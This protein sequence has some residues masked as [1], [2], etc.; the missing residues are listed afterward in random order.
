MRVVMVTQWFDPEPTFKGLLF[1]KELQRR[2]HEVEVVTGFPNY[3]GGRVYDGYRIRAYQREVIDGI[4]VHRVPL[5][6][7]HDSSAVKRVLNY[8]SFASAAA[9]KVLSGPRPEVIYAYHP[10]GTVALPAAV[11]RLVRGVPFVYDVQDLWPDT[12]S[13]TGMLSEGRV[14]R[15]VGRAMGATYGL[16]AHIVVLSEGFRARLLEGGVPS[17]KVTVIPNWAPEHEVV[18]DD[19]TSSRERLGLDRTTNVVFAGAIGPAQQLDVVLDAAEMMLSEPDVCF[20]L[21]GSGMDE[22]RLRALAS[23]RGLDNVRFLPRRP[24]SEVG[25]VLAAGDALLVHLRPDPLF[26]ITVP[27]K[28]QTYL[29]AGKPVLMGVRGDAARLVT[30]SGAGICFEPGNPA[31]LARAVRE[32]ARLSPEARRE[33]GRAGRRYYDERLSLRVGSDAFA[34]VLETAARQRHAWQR[35]K[36]GMDVAASAIGLTLF[37][38]PGAAVAVLVRTRLGSPVFFRQ[39]RPGRHGRPFTMVKFRTMTDEKDEQGHLLPDAARLTR[40][41]AW[42]RTTSLDELP[43]LWNVLKG[44]MS[45]V[46]PRPLLERYTPWYTAEEGRRLDVR[47]GVTG[48]AQVRGRNESA[49]DERLA[50]D[51][52]YVQTISPLRD[53]QIVWATV[54]RVF[55]RSGAVSDPTS[56]MDDLDVERAARAGGR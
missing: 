52:E 35:T 51:V 13:A 11:A 55:R 31:D 17:E 32:L 36:R 4:V 28:T 3:P 18:V 5:Y 14:T 42:L 50:L 10:P 53:L 30:E 46:G 25:E 9:L 20:V 45:V 44:D 2:G 49:W 39:Q 38:L 40:F 21:L 43:E 29:Y 41:G 27:S 1:A 19:E 48:L 15:L 26:E 34:T 23:E 7:S 24:P 33:M 16:A 56:I 6:P 37:A 8:V 54:A 47:P 12:L 22:Q